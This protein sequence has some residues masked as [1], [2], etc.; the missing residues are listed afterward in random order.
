M[1]SDQTTQLPWYTG[2][3][4]D[5]TALSRDMA[6]QVIDKGGSLEFVLPQ[7]T[8]QFAEMTVLDTTGNLVWKTQ[9]FNKNTIIWNKQ[10]NIG[11][12]VP[13]GR[14]TY[15]VKQGNRQVDGIALVA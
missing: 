15:R 7:G 3:V 6:V 9:T 2:I 11:K 5:E 4:N 10:T 13:I 14:Y 8:A 12:R 1:N